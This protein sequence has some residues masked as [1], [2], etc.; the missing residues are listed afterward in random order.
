MIS[1]AVSTSLLAALICSGPARADAEGIKMWSEKVTG[2]EIPFTVVEA[3]IEAPSSSVW[4]V[5]SHCADFSKTMPRIVASKELTRTGDEN[6]AFTTTCEVT[7]DLPFPLADLTSINK[8]VHSVEP[9]VKYTRRWTLVSGDYDINE[10][11]WTL[12][13]LDPKKTKATYRL[14]AKPKLPLPDS[15]IA[16]AQAQTMPDVMKKLRIT[17]RVP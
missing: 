17:T 7:A 10:G 15:F 16:T 14:R 5:V 11:S 6:S 3:V 12:V 4:A 13:A 1:K 8:A 9:N 2:S